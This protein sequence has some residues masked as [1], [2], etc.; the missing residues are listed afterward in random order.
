MNPI[1][2]ANSQP[3]D[4]FDTSTNESQTLASEGEEQLP[5]A[6][7]NVYTDVTDR[8]LKEL[9][10]VPGMTSRLG[11]INRSENVLPMM[12]MRA[13]NLP[14]LPD[15]DSDANAF[16]IAFEQ[17]N[18]DVFPTIDAGF[19]DITFSVPQAQETDKENVFDFT[20]GSFEFTTNESTTV[21]LERPGNVFPK[22]VAVN[23]P[24]RLLTSELD[25]WP[26]LI[27]IHPTAGQNLS[28]NY[29]NADNLKS[30]DD[31]HFYPYGWDFL[32]H[33]FWKYLFYETLGANTST[34]VGIVYQHQFSGKDVITV[35]PIL[36]QSDSINMGD[37]NN[38]DSILQIL[39]E[40]KWYFTQHVKMNDGL[41]S[42]DNFRVA[43][44]AYSSGNGLLKTFLAEKNNA[45]CQQILKEVYFFDAPTG[46]GPA[47]VTNAL[48]WAGNESDRFIR[49]Y[50]Q[51]SYANYS[52]IVGSNATVLPG[53]LVA[54]PDK[55]YHSIAL[56]NDSFW[57]Q[58]LPGLFPSDTGDWSQYHSLIATGMLTD[59]L[60]RSGF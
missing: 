44:A 2:N 31:A 42:T 16:L 4:D 32:F 10:V 46:I 18:V 58:L 13:T 26:V 39:G 53:Q 52:S 3:L 17:A 37:F 30:I 21:I 50:S 7:L 19:T 38:P 34:N 35:L 43:M 29:I 57:H 59:A 60:T 54:N 36:N 47:C 15:D 55:P 41:V 51:W 40:I 56:L 23:V 28:T 5:P 49:F 11:T 12:Q 24:N 1:P 14:E 8:V 9:N 20:L 22:L 45:F 6:P 33:M 27:Y 25:C 48:Q